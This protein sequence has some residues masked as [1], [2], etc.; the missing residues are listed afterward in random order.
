MN[1]QL[2]F[3]FFPPA[4]PQ[5]SG[6][7]GHCVSS[8]LPLEPEFLTVTYGAGGSTQ[9]RT[10]NTVEQIGRL[11]DRPVAGHLT[12]V[13]ATR[14]EISEVIDR[15]LDAG[16]RHIVAL[17]GDAPAGVSEP[18]SGGYRDAAELVS[19]IRSHNSITASEDFEISVGAY[20]EV[21][22]K[23]TS[24]Q[25]DIESLKAKLDAGATRAITQF[26]FEPEMYLRFRDQAQSFGITQPIIPGLMPITN[27]TKIASFSS[28][29]GATIP[30]WLIQRFDGHSDGDA[31]GEMIA[32]STAV[33]MGQRLVAEGCDHLHFYTMNKPELSLAVG[34]ML[35]VVGAQPA[36]V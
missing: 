8:L 10:Q 23:A 17:R 26:F 1:P 31:T 6:K 34:R 18:T 25:A 5:G 27:L 24:P 14:A 32:T 2:S 19:G 13:G 15:Y 9:E 11:T 36:L 35:T 28:K 30:S 20:P 33:E 7:L 22:P 3:E 16:V 4:T 21:H 12:C 29:I